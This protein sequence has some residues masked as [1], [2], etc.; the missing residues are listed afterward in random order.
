[1]EYFSRNDMVFSSFLRGPYLQ[2]GK[3]LGKRHLRKLLKA[4]VRRDC[5]DGLK[6]IEQ[7]VTACFCLQ[8]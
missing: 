7:K 6:T 8:V 5:L 3:K 4:V 1:M 2:G